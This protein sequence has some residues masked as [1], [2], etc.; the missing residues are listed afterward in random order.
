MSWK[1]LRE[2]RGLFRNCSSI[3]REIVLSDQF[4]DVMVLDL[5]LDNLGGDTEFVREIV[6]LLIVDDVTGNPFPEQ[7]GRGEKFGGKGPV[8]LLTV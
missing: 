4:C 8:R 7:G 5:V 1:G 6:D 2:S 3:S